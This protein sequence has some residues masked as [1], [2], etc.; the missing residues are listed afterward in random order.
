MSMGHPPLICEFLKISNTHGLHSQLARRSST[1]PVE[2]E[3][4]IAQ[5]LSA[6]DIFYPGLPFSYISS[7]SLFSVLNKVAL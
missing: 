4:S 1:K 3:F 2:I 7:A 6:V 5:L